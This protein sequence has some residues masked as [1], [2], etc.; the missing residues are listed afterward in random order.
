MRSVDI[1][2]VSSPTRS[3]SKG[4]Y[5]GKKSIFPEIAFS[6][7]PLTAADLSLGKYL[8]DYGVAKAVD[9]DRVDIPVA[10]LTVP[11]TLTKSYIETYQGL[12]FKGTSYVQLD[13][14]LSH[15]SVPREIQTLQPNDRSIVSGGISAKTVYSLRCPLAGGM[16][17]SAAATIEVGK[18]AVSIVSTMNTGT[19]R[20]YVLLDRAPGREIVYYEE[21]SA[22][23]LTASSSIQVDQNAESIELRDVN[24]DGL[25]DVIVKSPS[26]IFAY[27]VN[28]RNQL[29]AEPKLLYDGPEFRKSSMWNSQDR[30]PYQVL[31][32]QSTDGTLQLFKQQ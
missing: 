5:I 14:L 16:I 22:G 30:A 8:V 3:P 28:S 25:P 32:V 6:K 24:C 20:H 15:L 10:L 26:R 4:S 13:P 27:L 1:I 17:A 18:S 2:F 9:G 31:G 11:G 12:S 7:E 19:I 23:K 29:E 21:L